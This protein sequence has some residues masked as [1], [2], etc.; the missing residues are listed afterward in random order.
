MRLSAFRLLISFS[1]ACLAILTVGAL[2][3]I[4]V[5][6]QTAKPKPCTA[7]IYRQFDFWLG[8]F[9][10]FEWTDQKT[11]EARV[12][13]DTMLDGCAVRE[14]YDQNDGLH[15]ESITSYDGARQVWH[16]SW[17]TNYGQLME[18]EGKMTGD[19]ILLIGTDHRADG[20][21]RQVRD[22]WIP[23]EGGVRETAE[24]STDDGK[25]WQ[26]LFDMVFRPHKG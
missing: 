11:V 20:K 24:F 8:D 2:A 15:G 16:H 18:L 17:V 3:S 21:I 26:P 6:A 13:V 5:N 1:L 7:A 19:R 9:D 14:I 25:T 12:H 23:V 10:G 22:V 4:S